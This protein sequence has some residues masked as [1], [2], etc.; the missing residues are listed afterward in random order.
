MITRKTS[1][2]TTTASDK[3]SYMK[4]EYWPRL[5][6]QRLRQRAH[7]F[8]TKHGGKVN[9]I[10]ILNLNNDEH[11]DDDDNDE[12]DDDPAQLILSAAAD[13]SIHVSSPI[14][15]EMC[16]H[17]DGFSSKISSLCLC[18]NQNILITDG[19][20]HF[21]C[22]HDFDADEDVDKLYTLEP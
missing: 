4:I 18:E 3:S 17:M 20:Q 1:D 16:Y 9:S 19:M 13:G 6:S 14:G 22:L 12:E 5:A 7:V 10:Q 15:G 8:K 21:V 11:Y 2:S